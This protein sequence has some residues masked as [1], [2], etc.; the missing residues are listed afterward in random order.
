VRGS[1]TQ[2]VNFI[3]ENACEVLSRHGLEGEYLT[4][5]EL[6]F[7]HGRADVVLYGLCE[8][9][10]VMPVAIEVRGEF[11]SGLDVLGTI[12]EKMIGIYDHA[13]THVYI[14]V[15]GVRERVEDLVRTYLSELGYGLLKVEGD[16][17]DVIEEAKPKKPPG[18]DY[19]RVTS[20]GL[21]YLAVRRVLEDNGLNVNHITSEWIGYEK[22]I[23]YCG[24]LSKNHA[25]F[26][27][28]ARNLEATEKLL[29][30]VDTASLADAGYR[31]HI[32]VRFV[33][34]GKTIGNLHLCDEPLDRRIAKD[35]VLRLMKTLK[36][37]YKPC[38]VGFSIYK[39]LWNTGD[40]P[41]YPWVLEQ[42]RK[43]LSDK[44]LGMFKSIAR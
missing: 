40:V 4:V 17:I 44:E 33:V 37:V 6:R 32:E 30:A 7:P 2:I 34:V 28:Y 29:D 38:G 43:C 35:N 25:V 24:W 14:A 22:P 26:G 1:H 12:N 5:R 31:T 23:N 21:L 9:L 18:E 41:S 13:F 19:Y 36:T 10:S 16:R 20:Q 42:V 15:P 3:E 39:P 8:G 11:I 27:V